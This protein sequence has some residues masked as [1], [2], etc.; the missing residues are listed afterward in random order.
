MNRG[1]LEYPAEVNQRVQAR[2][3]RRRLLLLLLLLLA[4]AL[5]EFVAEDLGGA[6]DEFADSAGR[7]ADLD[8]V[9]A[10]PQS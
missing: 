2:H 5:D 10:V 1:A 8:V 7:C 4:G 6:D 3:S 9:R